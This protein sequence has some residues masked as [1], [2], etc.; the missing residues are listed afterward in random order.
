MEHFTST[1]PTWRIRNIS[2]NQALHTFPTLKLTCLSNPHQA[3]HSSHM[4]RSYD[5]EDEQTTQG[6]RRLRHTHSTELQPRTSVYSRGDIREQVRELENSS[7]TRV[8]ISPPST[9][10]PIASCTA[11]SNV[12]VGNV[13][14]AACR[15]A[16]RPRSRAASWAAVWVDV[17]PPMRIWRPMRPSRS[18]HGES[19]ELQ[20]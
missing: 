18:I 3:T 17:C 2:Y 8:N 16:V 11:S 12:H 15:V 1:H 4:E 6:R 5:S 20:A 14:L 10:S 13:S 9:A 7:V 19:A